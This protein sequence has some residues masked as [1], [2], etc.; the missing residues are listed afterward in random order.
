MTYP[1][2][3][4]SC[5]R[6]VAGSRAFQSLIITGRVADPLQYGYASSFSLQC[7]ALSDMVFHF[8]EDPDPDPALHQNDANLRP[9]VYIEPLKLLNFD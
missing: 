3:T 9:L 7:G 6:W 8:S 1:A 5:Q 2:P 4:L